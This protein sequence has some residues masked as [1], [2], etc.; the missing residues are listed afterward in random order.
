MNIEALARKFGVTRL[1]RLTGLDRLGVE[2]VGAVRPRGHVLQVSQG[3]GRT[4]EE[5][6]WRALS[7]A[8]ELTAAESPEPNAFVFGHAPGQTMFDFGDLRVAWVP[9]E[10]LHSRQRVCRCG[11]LPAR[12]EGVDG[13][14]GEPLE[15]ERSRRAPDV[16][17]GRGGTRAPRGDGTPPPRTDVA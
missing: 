10:D 1:A 17:D 12:R 11:V 4:L 14:V 3:K 7:E 15:I 16:E 6:R 2:V 9:A 13:T 5:A 8:I